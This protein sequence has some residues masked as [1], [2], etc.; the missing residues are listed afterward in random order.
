MP[1]VGPPA[2]G[3]A[4]TPLGQLVQEYMD[5]RHMNPYDVKRAGGPPESTVRRLLSKDPN[6]NRMPPRDAG[7]E[8][9]AV[10]L[11]C[12]LSRLKLAAAQTRGLV[13]AT[14]EQ[15]DPRARILAEA[16]EPLDPRTAQTVT[17]AFL[18]IAERFAATAPRQEEAAARFEELSERYAALLAQVEQ[19][20]AQAA[21]QEA[22]AQQ[23][24]T[25]VVRRLRQGGRK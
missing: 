12:P 4:M 8:A 20:K 15:V 3:G 25:P 9:L 6:A 23:E 11:R 5:L 1:E 24:G 19:G 22:L 7:L 13:G 18:L 10:A 14:H 17:D 21:G 16:L 2:D